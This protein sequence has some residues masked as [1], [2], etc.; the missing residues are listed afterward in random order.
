MLTGDQTATQVDA[1]AHIKLF[2]QTFKNLEMDDLTNFAIAQVA[3]STSLNPKIAGM[4]GIKHI[5]CPNY[6][7]N[8]G[9]K[10]TEKH[11][12]ELKNIADL[13]QEVHHKVKASNKLTV[14]LENVQAHH[15]ESDTS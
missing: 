6:C 9:C 4:L 2:E 10:D 15:Q 1:E 14:E 3:N 13:T 12:S 7:L 8:L 11:C 5:A